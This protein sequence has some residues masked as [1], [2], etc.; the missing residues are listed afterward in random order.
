MVVSFRYSPSPGFL[1]TPSQGCLRDC[2]STDT[3]IKPNLEK[4]QEHLCLYGG[5]EGKT[6]LYYRGSGKHM[7]SEEGLGVCCFKTGKSL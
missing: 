7:K 1:H 2:L 4:R 5:S 3:L 6:G